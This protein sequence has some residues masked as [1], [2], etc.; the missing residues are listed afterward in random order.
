MSV[1]GE[2]SN[3]HPHV[4]REHTGTQDPSSCSLFWNLFHHPCTL[5][6]LGELS[7][8]RGSCIHLQNNQTKPKTSHKYAT[9]LPAGTITN[10]SASVPGEKDTCFLN[11]F[12]VVLAPGPAPSGRR[13]VS[14]CPFLHSPTNLSRGVS[15]SLPCHQPCPRSESFLLGVPP[16]C[17]ILGFTVVTHE[18]LE[19]GSVLNRS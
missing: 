18:D 6:V 3:L 12:S 8:Q 19:M 16:F 13:P 15:V 7:P 2:I 17:K 14:T 4:G 10:M 11:S 5:A 9:F 1:P